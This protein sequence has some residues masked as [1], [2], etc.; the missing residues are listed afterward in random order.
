ME[1]PVL[2]TVRELEEKAAK[3]FQQRPFNFPEGRPYN[4][5]ESVLLALAEFLDVESELIP[6]IATGLGA[7]F[8]LNGLT[9]GSMSGAVMAIG[10]KYGRKSN[11]ESPQVAWSKVDSFVKAFKERW[12]ATSCMELTGL[13]IKTDEGFKEYYKNV[14]DYACTE[15]VKFAV[16]KAA[17]LLK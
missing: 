9:C 13:D 16:G 17:E 8:S 11:D 5:C 15:R 14:H 1:I 2:S 6:K 4:C 3:H 7:G 10:I 12:G